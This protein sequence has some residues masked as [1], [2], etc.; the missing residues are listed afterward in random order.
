MNNEQLSLTI[1]S[2]FRNTLPQNNGTDSLSLA[3]IKIRDARN[4]SI[5]HNEA[6]AQNARTLPTWG[7][8]EALVNYAKNF[9]TTMM[10]GFL[11]VRLGHRGSYYATLD[12]GST[13]IALKRLLKAADLAA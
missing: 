1:V 2:H 5:A 7:E 10:L 11:N 6:E 12:A 9:V 3:L 8:A 4:K 13:S